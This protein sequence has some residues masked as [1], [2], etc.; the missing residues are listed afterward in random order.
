[1]PRAL[2]TGAA[3][4]IGGALVRSLLERGWE[5]HG[6]LGRMCRVEALADLEGRIA[7]HPHDG[8]TEAM[9]AILERSRPDV[10]FHLASLFLSDHRPQDLDALVGS[11]ILLP[12]QLAEAMVLAGSTRLVNT[13]TSWQ[14]FHGE[15]Y[16]P[17]NLYAATKQAFEDILAYYHDARGL[18]A[19]TLK[20]FDTYG[21]GDLRPKL[22]NLLLDAARTGAPMALSPGEQ[23]LD[24]V[25]V[26]D[27]TAAFRAAAER[28][29]AAPAPLLE[30]WNVSGSR[31][32][33][34]QLVARIGEAVGRP[35][36]AT[37]GGRPYRDREVM[38][39]L[40]PGA[41]VPGWAPAVDLAGG[42]RT[43][44]RSREARP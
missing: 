28:L 2:V 39:P 41:G 14:H 17:V 8:S 35:V 42:L 18:S 43:A 44:Y 29:L 4:F 10:V 37:W 26:D 30:S 7:L 5:V 20:L 22:V 19:L 16:R 11:N 13:G 33:V 38:V 15:G 34:Q 9:V 27:V 3:G 24:L 1:M 23:V 40:A 21:P 32:T 25:H 12:A 36:Q 6:L 31:L